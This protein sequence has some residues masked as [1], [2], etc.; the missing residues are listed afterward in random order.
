MS[1]QLLAVGRITRAHGIRG[2]VAV[3]ALSEVP[4]R[5]VPGSTLRLEDGRSLTVEKARAHHQRHLVKFEQVADR[6]E[7]EALRGQ[8]LLVPAADAPPIEEEGRF[9]VHQVVGLD[10]VT[11][12]GRALGR[13][14]EVQ[15]NPANDLWVTDGGAVIPAVRQVV[16]EVDLDRR[17]VTVHELPGLLDEA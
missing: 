12:D 3:L 14:R 5:F 11:E 2:E 10:V 1:D 17:V 6:T 9:W 4:G 15:A 13:I 7:A 8:V 16:R